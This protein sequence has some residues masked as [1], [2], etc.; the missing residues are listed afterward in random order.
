[1]KGKVIFLFVPIPGESVGD[2]LER[3]PGIAGREGVEAGPTDRAP[4]V[5][6]PIHAHE[7]EQRLGVPSGQ[8]H[9]GKPDEPQGAA[10]EAGA[11]GRDPVKLGD[12]FIR[13]DGRLFLKVA[14]GRGDMQL[15]KEI[16]RRL[17]RLSRHEN[18]RFHVEIVAP[19]GMFSPSVLWEAAEAAGVRFLT[20][21]FFKEG[22]RG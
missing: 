10:V 20:V 22:R 7:P 21:A 2:A 4:M 17:G 3:A 6:T 15:A 12:I 1:M 13:E 18:S 8:S 16:H 14:F 19:L 9:R 11:A 5:P